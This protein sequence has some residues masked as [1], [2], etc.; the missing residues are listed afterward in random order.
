MKYKRRNIPE[1]DY[2]GLV[3]AILL[4]TFEEDIVQGDVR[5][6]R[7]VLSEIELPVCRTHVALGTSW[8]CFLFEST[9]GLALDEIQRQ[10]RG[11]SFSGW[12][13]ETIS[14]FWQYVQRL[15]GSR[16]PEIAARRGS[17]NK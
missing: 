7:S 12:T 15:C 3:L 17:F 13:S 8:H 5:H 16:T 4:R 14:Q 11:Q 10:L 1:S 9:H 2:F 6:A